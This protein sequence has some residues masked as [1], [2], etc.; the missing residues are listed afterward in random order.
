MVKMDWVT[1]LCPL[2]VQIIFQY[3][4]NRY[5]SFG[6]IPGNKLCNSNSN[7]SYLFI[8]FFIRSL[9]LGES[10]DC[11]GMVALMEY[12]DI[13]GESVPILMFFKHGLLEEK[14]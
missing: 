13:G 12:R 4:R 7:F 11:D 14:F 5:K 1:A 10:M 9:F 3:P 2:L 6:P 8:S